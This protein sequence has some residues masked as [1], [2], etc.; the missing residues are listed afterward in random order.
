[1]TLNGVEKKL[2]SFSLNID[3]LLIPRPGIFGLIGPNGSGKSTLAKIMA[4]LLE[5]DRG[6]IDTEG[7]GPRDITFI[8]R[9]PYLLNDT[10]YN[11]LVYPLK[12]RR[13]KPESSLIDDYLEKMG[14]PDRRKQ[15]ARSLSGGEQQKLSFLRALIFKPR[16]I[17]VDEALT[18]LDIDSLDFF[19]NLILL[20]QQKDPVT[21]IIISHRM[22]HIRRLSDHV[23]FMYDGK[24][25]N[26]GSVEEIMGETTNHHL[27]KYLRIYGGQEINETS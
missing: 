11:N 1:M 14:F 2:G 4:G 17:I 5:P 12:I 3:K 21:W 23:F 13:M 8:G 26:E 9:K 16:F 19:E 24:I 15:K 27:S 20:E 7:L 10:V 18:A 6:S 22:S 25:E